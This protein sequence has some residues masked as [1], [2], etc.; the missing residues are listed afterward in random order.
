MARTVGVHLRLPSDYP[1]SHTSH[2]VDTS[3]SPN[4]SHSPIQTMARRP[5]AHPV[6]SLASR[7]SVKH[8]PPRKWD[9]LAQWLSLRGC[10]ASRGSMGLWGI[11]F[12]YW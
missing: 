4:Y 9:E 10:R 5:K 2:L 8:R 6:A 11:S 1:S 7:Q 12:L 3:P